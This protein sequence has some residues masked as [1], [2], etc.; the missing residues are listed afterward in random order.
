VER[1]DRTLGEGLEQ[2]RV[3]AGDALAHGP[4]YMMAGAGV[5]RVC[6]L[7]LERMTRDG[8]HDDVSLIAAQRIARTPAGFRSELSANP[9]ALTK[10]REEL[11]SW[12]ATLGAAEEDIRSIQLAVGEAVTNAVEHAYPDGPGPVL[13]EGYH[14]QT[15][16]ACLTVSDEG[17][18]RPPTVTPNA[19]GRGLTMIRGC[20][21]TTEIERSEAGTA[22]LM[23]LQLRRPSVF[24]A[25]AVTGVAP[26]VPAATFRAVTE[27]A[28][29]PVLT[30]QGPVDVATV[31]EFRRRLQ[32]ATRGGSLPLELDLSRVSHLASAGIQAL[33]ELAEQMAADGNELLVHAPP[34]C[35]ARQVLELTGLDRLVA[36]VEPDT[37][38]A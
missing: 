26:E 32:D 14:D 4:T 35:P 27:R 9:A 22:V 16:R 3:Y 25:S 5:D 12:L 8:F 37:G 29:R 1:P 20:M 7:S 36:D 28:V 18:W 23:D 17:R 34:R 2:L 6:R 15:G 24:A 31:P 38:V 33:H 13:V 10:L 11:G 21:D 19:R 30:V